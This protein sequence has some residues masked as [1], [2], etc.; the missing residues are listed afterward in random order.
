MEKTISLFSCLWGRRQPTKQVKYAG[1]YKVRW[2]INAMEKKINSIRGLGWHE[3]SFGC[4]RLGRP[5]RGGDNWAKT[6]IVEKTKQDNAQENYRQGKEAMV[7]THK[8]ALP[9]LRFSLYSPNSLLFIQR[10]G[11]PLEGLSFVPHTNPFNIVHLSRKVSNQHCF[12]KHYCAS[13]PFDFFKEFPNLPQCYAKPVH[14]RA[15]KL[16][17]VFLNQKYCRSLPF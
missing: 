3:R 14:K 9:A 6:R 1:N 8:F 2:G 15:V 11:T 12:S 5:L 4:A 17:M 13:S 7:S 16:I 10:A